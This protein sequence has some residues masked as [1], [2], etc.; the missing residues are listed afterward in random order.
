MVRE[1]ENSWLQLWENK[2]FFIILQLFKGT[3]LKLSNKL[4]LSKEIA[5]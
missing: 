2:N 3:I 4:K 5:N 1:I